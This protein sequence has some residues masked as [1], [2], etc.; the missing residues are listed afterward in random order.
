MLKIQKPHPCLR[1]AG[2]WFSGIILE[3]RQEIASL[4]LRRAHAENTKTPS[5]P[6]QGWGLV[7]RNHFGI[8]P[9]DSFAV[10]EEGS[11]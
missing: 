9:R 8:S 7:Q 11:C 1:R 6:S 5:L 10:L 2:V 4:F 3:S